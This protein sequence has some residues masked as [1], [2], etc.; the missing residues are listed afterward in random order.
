MNKN[1]NTVT[2]LSNYLGISRKTLYKRA[3]EHYIELNGSYSTDDLNILSNNL[4]Q[5][6]NK[7]S[8]T[9]VTPKVN[10]GNT[11]SKQDKHQNSPLYLELKGQINVLKDDKIFLQKEIE[12]KT[13][14]ISET[15]K[16]L[17]QAQQ[18]QLDLQT[19]LSH[20]EQE[21]LTLLSNAQQ[22]T[23]T[24]ARVDEKEQTIAKLEAQISTD[25]QEK[26]DL[27]EQLAS[28]KDYSSYLHS[29][30]SELENDKNAL[31]EQQSDADEAQQ[32]IQQLQIEL[33]ETQT[34]AQEKDRQRQLMAE[35]AENL[36][37]KLTDIRDQFQTEQNKGFW[38]RLFGR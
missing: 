13:K 25:K 37:A 17:D 35:R 31:L 28:Q 8:V 3:K 19:K 11:E 5:Q 30:K 34:L 9:P 14:T 10:N 33:E 12:S 15:N 22:L 29:K 23:D 21:R 6:S 16:L 27:Q 36:S 20:S 7:K 38:Q 1:F 26:T 18:L 24:N 4:S 32:M 2:D